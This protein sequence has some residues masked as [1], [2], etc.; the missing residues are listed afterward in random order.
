MS[1][2]VHD[3]SDRIFSYLRRMDEDATTIT[4]TG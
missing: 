2:A 1:I 4:N 3:L